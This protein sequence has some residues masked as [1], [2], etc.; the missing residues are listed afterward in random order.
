MLQWLVSDLNLQNRW[1]LRLRPHHRRH[2]DQRL[3]LLKTINIFFLL[4][5]F[6]TSVY[7]KRISIF[8]KLLVDL[9]PA[10]ARDFHCHSFFLSADPQ[11]R[12]LAP[13]PAP[14]PP[15]T[16]C[17]PTVLPI[18]LSLFSCDLKSLLFNPGH[19]YRRQV[20][21]SIKKI[22]VL[23]VKFMSRKFFHTFQLF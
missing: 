21:Y 17:M 7:K 2:K 15:P 6:H 8:I 16:A 5:S 9:N 22:K 10:V 4:K 23:A 14:P 1:R 12:P 3:R 13:R 19:L 18:F 20:S 11:I